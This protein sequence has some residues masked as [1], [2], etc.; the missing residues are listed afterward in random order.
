MEEPC[1]K[2]KGEREE[3]RKR[4]KERVRVCVRERARAMERWREGP[5]RKKQV[6]SIGRARPELVSLVSSFHETRTSLDP[7]LLPRLQMSTGTC[8]QITCTQ[9]LGSQ[10]C[11]L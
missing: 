3:E 8:S 11:F 4:A 5:C 1:R 2:K 6:V 7:A 9:F 10:N